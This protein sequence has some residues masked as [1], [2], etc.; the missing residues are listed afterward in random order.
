M[1][2]KTATK[3]TLAVLLATTG[4]LG[5]VVLNG[6]A[7]SKEPRFPQ[8][9]LEQLN[10][11]QRPIGNRIASFSSVGIQGPYNV[12]LRSPAAATPLLDQLDYLRFH[13]RFPNRLIE[14]AIVIQARLWRSQVEWHG[15][16][17]TALKAGV[18]EQTLA[19]LKMNKRPRAM[20]PDEEAVYDFCTELFTQHAV[21]DDTYARLHR[22][23]DDQQI[24]DLTTLS[25]TYGTV[26]ALLAMSEQSVVPPSAELP[27]KPGEP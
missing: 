17:P 13:S 8:L 22:L 23:F 19:D 3:L 5:C 14:F 11:E 26:A 18:S 1:V 7:M 9:T 25:G 6:S 24:V 2:M 27:F 16:Y 20:K 4:G 15:H 21:S 10:S 12:M